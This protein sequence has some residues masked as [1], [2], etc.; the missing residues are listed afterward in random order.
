MSALA[1]IALVL[2]APA[3]SGP[4][5][6]EALAR[7]AQALAASNPGAALER[8][9]R[10]LAASAEFLP[11]DFVR[12]GRKGEVVEDAYRAARDAYRRHRAVLYRAVGEAQLAA[13]QPVAAARYLARA[14]LL[15]PD[16]SA[17]PALVAARL[18]AGQADA[19]LAIVLRRSREA[20]SVETRALA[21][22]A[23]D[24]AGLPSLQA[25]LDR[26]RLL[27]LPEAQRPQILEGPLRAPERSRLS[28][29]APFRLDQPGLTLVYLAAAGCTSCSADLLELQ[30]AAPQGARLYV[31]PEDP[32][33]DHALRQA[34]RAYR[35]DWPVVIGA[36]LGPA[37]ELKPPALLV[38][39]R[40]GFS[41]AVVQP[42][43]GQR[44]GGVLAVLAREDV[45]E[46]LPRPA[47]NRRPPVRGAALTQPG[48]S[49]EGL[50]PGE[51]DPA[52]AE[53][54]AV[55][56]AYRAGRYTEA[57]RGLE[58]LENAS[59]WLLPPEA[60]F[61]RALCLAA[62]GR[63]DEARR[64]LLRIGDSRFQDAVDQALE[65]VAAGARP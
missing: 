11:T 31:A 55:L 6:A 56:A 61:D 13:G 5:Q 29:G 21:E 24:A 12:A 52:P 36:P 19:A 1:L 2:L 39:G 35:Y 43:F 49:L 23:A 59:G 45:Q 48:L 22:R 38:V 62:L 28:T 65:R 20:L 4:E 7:E 17:W 41:A 40:G 27:A 60:R 50:A 8:A 33:Q 64:M 18:R 26:A 16:A 30:R 53:F 63:R 25:E 37:L 14:E 47:W 46:T 54:G 34:L 9:S 57:L 42:P 15:D 10:A 32:A 44:L 58:G 51:D 3:P